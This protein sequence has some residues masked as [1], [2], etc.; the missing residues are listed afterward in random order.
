MST[1]LQYIF[2]KI[3]TETKRNCHEQLRW[4]DRQKESFFL[5]SG[6]KEEEEEE[7]EEENR[8]IQQSQTQHV[9]SELFGLW[10]CHEQ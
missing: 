2:Q 7:E 6:L 1:K 9:V 10:L 5:A 8:I 3:S 4:N